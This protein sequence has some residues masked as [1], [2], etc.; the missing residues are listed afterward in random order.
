MNN[1]TTSEP[2]W[3]APLP[4]AHGYAA[5]DYVINRHT[6]RMCKV[7]R[8]DGDGGCVLDTNH[9]PLYH[10]ATLMTHHW[11]PHNDQAHL[12]QPGK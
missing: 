12:R 9:G 8:V 5:G 10:S 2:Q 11:K 1:T 3:P 4:V 7:L 6:N